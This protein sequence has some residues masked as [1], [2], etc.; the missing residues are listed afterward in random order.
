MGPMA[1]FGYGKA[2]AQ[3]L[4]KFGCG[5]ELLAHREVAAYAKQQYLL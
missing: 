1:P 5:G 2:P 4:T 3:G